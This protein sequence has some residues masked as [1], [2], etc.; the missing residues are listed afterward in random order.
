MSRRETGEDGASYSGSGS[1]SVPHKTAPLYSAHNMAVRKGAPENKGDEEAENG[2][3]QKKR[4]R[5]GKSRYVSLL[6][7][8]FQTAGK[9]ARGRVLT[10][11]GKGLKSQFERF[12]RRLH[13]KLLCQ[14]R[15]LRNSKL[16]PISKEHQ[17]QEEDIGGNRDWQR[18]ATH[19]HAQHRTNLLDHYCTQEKF[20]SIMRS[21]GIIVTAVSAIYSSV[22]VVVDAGTEQ[23]QSPTENVQRPPAGQPSTPFPTFDVDTPPPQ[24][25]PVPPPTPVVSPPTTDTGM[26]MEMHLDCYEYGKA[27]KGGCGKSGKAKGS[28]GG[29]GGYD[30]G[31]GSSKGSKMKGG[32]SSKGGYGGDDAKSSK[33]GY[34]GY[35]AK[36]SKGGYGGDDAKS[37]KGGYGGDD[38]KSS[39]GGYGGYDAKSSKGAYAAK[40]SKGTGYGQS[41]KWQDYDGR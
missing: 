8:R 19:N 11:R 29:Y 34:G 7:W 9:I 14:E 16:K 25:R 35:D 31:H 39:K 1:G 22:L 3:P 28:K 37:S 5:T 40:S 26:S 41:D 33:G 15:G 4:R 23:T 18:R 27:S 6:Y 17:R 13:P 21:A 10:S 24:P 12:E 20:E 32:K 36:S 38:A 2:T 30:Y